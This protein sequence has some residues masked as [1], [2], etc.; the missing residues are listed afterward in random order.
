MTRSGAWN[1]MFQLGLDVMDH[2]CLVIGGGPEAEEKTG[3]LLRAGANETIVSPDLTRELSRLAQQ[4]RLRHRRRRFELD[5][6][7]GVFI[8]LN[9]NE[10]ERAREIYDYCMEHRIL[11]NT[12]DCV[13]LSVMS[14]A[15]LVDPGHLRIS[16]ST[17]NA[18]PAL[19][20]RLRRDLEYLFDAEF[21]EYLEA[22]GRVRRC[23]I[24][25][26][27]DSESRRRAL[28]ELAADFRLEGRLT[29]P[30]GWRERTS[31]LLADNTR[32]P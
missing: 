26:D 24:E 10:M 14:M 11:V 31:S 27:L 6:L 8:V 30:P 17:S 18:S 5:D 7:E 28:K 4:H 29:Y 15:A 25:G 12:Y 23:L 22:L 13:E 3:R 32:K 9:T 16:I 19:A 21:V 1:P 2:Q 20:G